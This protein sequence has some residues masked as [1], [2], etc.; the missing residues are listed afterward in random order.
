MVPI[1]DQGV[2]TY[3]RVLRSFAG[4]GAV[5]LLLAVGVTGPA[6]A[7]SGTPTGPYAGMGTCPLTSSQLTSSSS[8]EVGCVVA[9]IGGGSITIGGISVPLTGTMT[10]KFGFYWPTNGPS[11]TFPDGNVADVFTTVAPTDGNELSGPVLDVPIPGLSNYVPGLTSA[12]VQVELAGPITD[13]APLSTGENY[14]RFRL[15]LKFHLWNAFLGTNCYVGSNSS[16]ILLEPT[17]G[18]TAP[19]SPNAPVTG[20]SGTVSL[21][22][23]PNG[24]GDLIV[25]FAGATLVDNS[26]SVPGASGC[27]LI[28]GSANWLVNLLF[29]LGS[30]AGHNSATLTNV[31]TTLAADSSISDLTSAIQASE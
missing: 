4:S 11:V 14:P 24:F 2:R 5:A 8:A 9:T 26:F 31:S 22:S 12:F 17:A 27:G 23:D 6:S 7:A 30:A 15:P 16:P 21:N 25:G 20:N 1:V 3:M 29:G 10:A 19:P 13:F 18:T 28:S